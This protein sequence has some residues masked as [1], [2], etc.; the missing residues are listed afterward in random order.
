MYST[1]YVECV[2]DHFGLTLTKSIHCDDVRE[3]NF[4]IF[5]PLTIRAKYFFPSLVL[6]SAMF[7]LN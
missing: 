5:V 1:I 7:P 3:N 6:S 2:G 4:Y